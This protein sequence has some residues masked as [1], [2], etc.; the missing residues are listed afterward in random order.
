MPSS[1]TV[2]TGKHREVLDI[3]EKLNQYLEATGDGICHVFVLHTTASVACVDLDPGADLDY[4]DAFEAIAPKLNY[5]H[6]HDPSHFPDHVLS[7]L[8]GTSLT[9]PVEKGKLVLGT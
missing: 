1:F 3:T 5:R 6:P 4:L 7:T 2:K 9:L 8:I